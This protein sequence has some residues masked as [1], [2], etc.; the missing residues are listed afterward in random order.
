VRRR[1]IVPGID[2]LWQGDLLVLDKLSRYNK[3]F[4]YIL[5]VIDVFSKVAFVEPLKSKTEPEVSNA[6][7]L[8][9]DRSKRHPSLFQVDEGKEFFNSYVK[10]LM[11]DMN[12]KMFHNHFDTKACVVERFQR[13]LMGRIYR[14]FELRKTKNYIDVLE[15]IVTSYNNSFHSSIKCNP[16]N[17]NKY[18]EM[19]TW[20]SL[21]GSLKKREKLCR[22]SVLKEGDFVRIKVIR[23]VFTKGYSAGFTDQV[24]KIEEVVKSYPITYKLVETDR[25]KVLGIFYK[26]E[27]SKITI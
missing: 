23:N 13:T 8:I 25:S 19:E 27:L 4:K 15:D 21:Y 10:K 18:N 5:S 24:F 9:F 26:E 20:M 17:V 6:L 1:V 3:G 16:N 14:F 22:K 7:K 2:H 11:S 12:I